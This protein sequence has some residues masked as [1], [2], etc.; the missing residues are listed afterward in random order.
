[1]RLDIN[2]KLKEAKAALHAL[3]N[4]RAHRSQQLDFL[5]D[6]VAK[7]QEIMG[8]ALRANYGA[9]G[10][11][12]KHKRLRLATIVVDRNEQF[13]SDM[14]RL[15]HVYRFRNEAETTSQPPSTSPNDSRGTEIQAT[16]RKVETRL[17]VNDNLIESELLSA[18]VADDIY[19]W[20]ETEY[21]SSRGFEVGTF[22]TSLLPTVMRRQSKKWKSISLGYI[23][24]IIAVVN[25]FIVSVLTDICGDPRISRG[26]LSIMTDGLH[27]AYSKAVKHTIF[28]L[29]NERSDSLMSLHQSFTD[30]L[31]SR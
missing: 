7:F 10:I 28:L 2:K 1:M 6:I 31:Q 15:G 27:R 26:L 11:F 5:L 21:R 25:S 13:K 4:E 20:L 3:G 14:M 12:D 29:E 23:S 16:T 24:D 19:K 18:P 30:T 8:N 9:D 17:D 22:N